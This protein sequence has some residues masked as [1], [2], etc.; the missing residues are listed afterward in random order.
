MKIKK[1]LRYTINTTKYYQ[2]T[3]SCYVTKAVVREKNKALKG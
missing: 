3:L 2:L 1:A